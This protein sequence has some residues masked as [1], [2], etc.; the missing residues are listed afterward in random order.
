MELYR[1]VC[2]ACAD[3]M[4]RRA[5]AAQFNISRETV[6]KALAFSVPPGYR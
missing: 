4:S 5:A 6:D 1:K 2:L 3:G